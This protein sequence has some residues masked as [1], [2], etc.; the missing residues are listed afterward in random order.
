M[1]SDTLVNIKC[2]WVLVGTVAISDLRLS[3]VLGVI[4]GVDMLI[5]FADLLCMFYIISTL[6]WMLIMVNPHTCI[7]DQYSS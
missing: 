1:V 2:I 3:V 5:V 4:L 7:K 6:V